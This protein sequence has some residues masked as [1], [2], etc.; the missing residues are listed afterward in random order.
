MGADTVPTSERSAFKSQHGA[1]VKDYGPYRLA[2]LTS[3]A[4]EVLAVTP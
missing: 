3:L 4:T 1:H 2:F